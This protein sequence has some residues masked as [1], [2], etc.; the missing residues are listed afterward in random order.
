MPNEPEDLIQFA[1]P[2]PKI[3]IVCEHCGSE[4]VRRDAWACWDV[5][6]Q[7]WVLEHVMDDGYCGECD[8]KSS[9]KE[10]PV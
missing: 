9:L 7:D 5:E 8:G 2:Q 1:E 3:R 4:N 6:T 10:V